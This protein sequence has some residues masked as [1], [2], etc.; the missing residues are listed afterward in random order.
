MTASNREALRRID[1]AFRRGIRPDPLP[2]PPGWLT[3]E[4]RSAWL[5]GARKGV[6]QGRRLAAA[7]A[8]VLSRR[9][10][11]MHL[12]HYN[13]S[14]GERME[15]NIVFQYKPESKM[16]D[17]ITLTDVLSP[18]AAGSAVPSIGDIVTLQLASTLREFQGELAGN[19][20]SF[21][22]IGRT[23]QITRKMGEE[24]KSSSAAIF[25]SSSQM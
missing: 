4:Q 17:D 22:V 18:L 16:P 21:Q 19:F 6:T 9:A 5:L 20:K 7:E 2:V 3:P 10:V 8:R 12:I 1:T 23:S 15:T 25:I 11:V 24:A 14:A 13:P